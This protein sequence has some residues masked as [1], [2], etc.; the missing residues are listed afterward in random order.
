VGVLPE[1]FEEVNSKR[2]VF[3]L[4]KRIDYDWRSRPKVV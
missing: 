2:S 4:G 1:E 3:L